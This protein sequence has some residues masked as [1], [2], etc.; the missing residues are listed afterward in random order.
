MSYNVINVIIIL[1]IYVINNV[2]NITISNGIY[3]GVQ[4]N[5]TFYII[6]IKNNFNYI[7]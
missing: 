3:L 4:V 6:I 2:E 7:N 1:V 5:L